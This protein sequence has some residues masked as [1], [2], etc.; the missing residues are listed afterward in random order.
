MPGCI[1]LREAIFARWQSYRGDAGC[2]LHNGKTDGGNPS[3]H[4][5]G[6]AIDIW[7]ATGHTDVGQSIFDWCY[8]NRNE[9]GLNEVIFNRRIWRADNIAHGIHAYTVNAHTDHIHIALN[10]DGARGLLPF[11]G[12]NEAIPT[13]P[14]P[15]PEGD[16]TMDEEARAAFAKVDAKLE[17]LLAFDSELKGVPVDDP[18]LAHVGLAQR[19]KNVDLGLGELKRGFA[20][21]MVELGQKLRARL[22]V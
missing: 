16:L 19:I 18:K 17:T 20:G 14:A 21:S 15:L 9:I 11:Y 8:A 5:R 1:S 10:L 7:I 22:G 2:Y 13:A 12:G 3:F 4:S 6:R